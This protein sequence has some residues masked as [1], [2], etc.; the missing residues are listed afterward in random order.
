MYP[1]VNPLNLFPKTTFSGVTNAANYGWDSRFP[2]ADQVRQYNATDNVTKIIG[3]HVLKFGVDAETDSYLQPNHNRV[4]T[5]SFNRDTSNPNDSNFAYSNAILGNLDTYTQITALLNYDP[6]TNALEWYYQDTWKA[7]KN[8][9]LDFGI[10]NSWAMA[11][12]LARGNNFVPSL[13]NSGERPGSL[14][15]Q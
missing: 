12:R 5:F 7:K 13:Y 14:S 3:S 8:L 1:G 4:G 6:R 11:Q 2:M 15:V 9:T 10:R